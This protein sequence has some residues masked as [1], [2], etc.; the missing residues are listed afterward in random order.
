VADDY[1]RE[2]AAVIDELQGGAGA[3]SVRGDGNARFVFAERGGRATELSRSDEG[4]WV[5]F[6]ASEE[7]VADRTFAS[8]E[9]SAAAARAWLAADSA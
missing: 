5:E 6:W 3:C 4:W 7:V 1:G 2:L 8:A 9:E